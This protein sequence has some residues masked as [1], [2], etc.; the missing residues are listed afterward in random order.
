MH[1]FICPWGNRI[2]VNVY[3]AARQ[4]ELSGVHGEAVQLTYMGSGAGPAG[5]VLARP[6][7]CLI[8][9][10]LLFIDE[11]RVLGLTCL[12]SFCLVKY[13]LEAI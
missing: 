9:E 6:L 3:T 11:R 12:P 1:L 2:N 8:N 13:L 7:F 5:Q 4:F 10:Q